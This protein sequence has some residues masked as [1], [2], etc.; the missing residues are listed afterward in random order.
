M[1]D[2]IEQINNWLPYIFPIVIGILG[3]GFIVFKAKVRQLAA[4][5]V[6]MDNALADDKVTSE[7]Y[8]NLWNLGRQLFNK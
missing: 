1:T 4:F 6:A 5:F 3:G 8:Q 2:P 7:E